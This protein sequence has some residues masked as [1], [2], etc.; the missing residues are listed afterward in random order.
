M[1]DGHQSDIA[2]D[3][4]SITDGQCPPPVSCSF[5]TGLC[6]F[7]NDK[8]SVIDDFDWVVR[9]GKTPSF[10]TGPPADH[11]R[12]DKLGNYLSSGS[13][14][15][16]SIHSIVLRPSTDSSLSTQS[17]YGSAYTCSHHQFYTSVIAVL[18]SPLPPPPAAEVLS[19]VLMRIIT[20]CISGGY[21][22]I[23]SSVPRQQGDIARLRSEIFELPTGGSSD[24]CLIFWYHMYGSD[25]GKSLLKRTPFTAVYY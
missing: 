1:G 24:Y 20:H 23:E 16:H 18:S 11:T 4:Y 9:T 25:I 15:G 12:G 2:I 14:Y 21:A 22:F 8:N 19:V 10:L 17:L 7:R 13:S 5:E 6:D 3:D